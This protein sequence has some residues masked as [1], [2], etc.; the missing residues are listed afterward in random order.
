MRN[1]AIILASV[2]TLAG[3]GTGKT[4]GDSTAETQPRTAVTLTHA[5]YGHITKTLTFQAR[6]AYLDKSSAASPISGFI[7]KTYVQQGMRIGPGQPLYDIESKER[8]ATGDGGLITIK[9]MHRGIVL[10]V[11]QQTGSYVAE[12]TVLCT[13]AESE[14][15][16][17][18]MNIPYE[19]RG[20]IKEGS[21]CIMELPDGTKLAATVM[22]PLATMNTASQSEQIIASAKSGFLPEGLNVNAVFTL[23]NTNSS[24]SMIL[25]AGAVQ[26]DESIKKHWVMKLAADNTA[27]KVPV[28]VTGRSTSE[29]EVI[30]SDI[31][32][33]D[34]IILEGSYG[35]EDGAAVCVKESVSITGQEESL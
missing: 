22:Q 26:S 19:Q 34:D 35:L 29:I 1:T 9:A 27:V 6:T 20:Y 11:L 4:S 16:I 14:S 33:Q 8:H 23:R 13:T 24:E 25:P 3:C 7:T 10:D 21:R 17:F 31:T 32:P 5:A 2:L 12:G 28:E 15:L 18:V 30:S